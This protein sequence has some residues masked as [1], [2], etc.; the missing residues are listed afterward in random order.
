MGVAWLHEISCIYG[1][2]CVW[3]VRVAHGVEIAR[4]EGGFLGGIVGE[5]GVARGW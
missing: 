4:R 1:G 3:V 2:W 5:L